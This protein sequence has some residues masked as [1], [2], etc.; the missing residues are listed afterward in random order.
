MSAFLA[1]LGTKLADRWLQALLLPGLLYTALLTAALELGQHH[2]FDTTRIAGALNR[3][4]TRPAAHAPGT[5]LLTAAAILLASAGAGLLA[6]AFGRVV[7]HLW[8]LSGDQP[9]AA[10]LL[11]WRR[12][13]WDATTARLKTAILHAADPARHELDPGRAA[14]RVRALQRRRARLGPHRPTHPTRIA[15]RFERTTAR[16][17]AVNGL[18]DLA[19]TWPR[20]AAVLPDPLRTDLA[21]ARDQYSAAA[22]LAAWSVLTTAVAFAWWPAALLGPALAATTVP[23]ARTAAATLATLIETAA[24]LHLNTLANQLGL[25]IA[26]SPHTGHAITAY[27]HPTSPPTQNLEPTGLST[28][29]LS[30]PPTAHQSAS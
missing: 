8:A 15:D 21:T 30:A 7:Q 12:Q 27:L 14:V 3:L 22:R 4:A 17:A 2:P 23:R 13:R 19:L 24:D 1:E 10:W 6:D 16:A 18:S 26:S 11:R 20:L 9:P 29:P 25:P 28:P 5:V